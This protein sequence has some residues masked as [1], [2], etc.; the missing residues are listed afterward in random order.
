VT[1]LST[2]LRALSACLL[3]AV[4]ASPSAPAAAKAPPG[5]YFPIE[6][7]SVVHDAITGLE[8]T[9]SSAGPFTHDE[10]RAHCEGL[11]IGK[12]KGFRVP[13]RDQLITLIDVSAVPS[14][15]ARPLAATRN[16]RYFDAPEGGHWTDTLVR[17]GGET[18]AV[19]FAV[20][21][22]RGDVFPQP[23]TSWADPNVLSS[24]YVR[25]VR[26]ATPGK[27]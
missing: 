13:R 25:C 9:S 11:Q 5:R 14:D 3:A 27:P 20:G 24:L 26:A 17:F 12:L 10:A 15:A 1:C 4:V 18:G 22:E 19:W 16:V 7:G 2:P 8:W 6:D 23:N 21:A